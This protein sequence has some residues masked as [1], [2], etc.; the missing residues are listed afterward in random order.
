MARLSY[1]KL[2]IGL[3]F[4]TFFQM[5]A[6]RDACNQFEVADLYLLPKVVKLFGSTIKE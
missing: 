2:T 1:K 6:W 3:L 4:P 5:Q